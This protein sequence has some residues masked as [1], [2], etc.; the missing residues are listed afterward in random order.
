MNITMQNIL[1]GF[2]IITGVTA[3]VALFYASRQQKIDANVN[4]SQFL[5]SLKDSF[6]QEKRYN[7]HVCLRDHNIITDWPALDDYLGMF[8]VCE[9]M[10]DNGTLSLEAFNSLYKY[11][12][13]NILN[14]NEIVM[15]K[16]LFEYS[17]WAGLYKLLK[18]VFPECKDDFIELENMAPEFIKR[19][20]E[21]N[22]GYEN[23]MF[24]RIIEDDKIKLMTKI[25]SIRNK[26]DKKSIGQ[27]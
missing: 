11:R 18:K 14:Y 26:M 27:R 10:I 12:L 20:M 19:N 7:I 13:V 17:N 8:E 16:L 21:M 3:I 9:V 22:R 5:L 4:K 6:A 15:Y 2:Q 23:N 24:D 25:D 1:D